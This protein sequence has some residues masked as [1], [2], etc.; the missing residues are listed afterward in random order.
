MNSILSQFLHQIA[1]T[2]SFSERIAQWSVSVIE[3]LG[4]PGAALLIAIENLFPP[5]PSEVILPLAGFTASRGEL[6]L[7]AVI[8]WTT[9]GSLVGA[10]ALYALG[11]ILGR[12][13]LRAI[14]IKMPL[15]KVSDF[16]KTE[17]WFQKHETQ[18]VFWGRMIPIFRSLI[19]IPA[20]VERMPLAQF[21]LYTTVGSLI[22]NSVLIV[23]GYLLGEQ[24]EKV[25]AYVSILQYVVIA[26][27]IASAVW[28]IYSRLKMKNQKKTELE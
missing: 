7:I 13:R 10:L 18:T 9:L 19:S 26:V 14:V 6:G 16:D 22:W 1:A 21:A 8:I 24:W 11:A 2:Q 15:I 27:V 20:G 28:F 4:G 17:K 5:L 12:D 3:T 23:A 25:G